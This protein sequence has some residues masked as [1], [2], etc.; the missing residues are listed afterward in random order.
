[1]RFSAAY[2]HR[3]HKACLCLIKATSTFTQF[4][5]RNYSLIISQCVV[6]Y[7]IDW[8]WN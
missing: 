3:N 1:M 4:L 6:N 8:G 5:S 7:N 2:V